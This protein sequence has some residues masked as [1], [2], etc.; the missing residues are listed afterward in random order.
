MA[1]FVPSLPLSLNSA[2]GRPAAVWRNNSRGGVRLRAIGR[3]SWR[4]EWTLD[5]QEASARI[6]NSGAVAL[7]EG[8]MIFQIPVDYCCGGGVMPRIRIFSGTAAFRARLP[9]RDASHRAHI[10]DTHLTHGCIQLFR[11]FS[12]GGFDGASTLALENAAIPPILETA[13]RRRRR[14]Q[15]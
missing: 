1:T 9:G 4:R 10:L 12:S 6:A 13:Y 3:P 7:C 8:R 5:W 2:T 14:E 11:R 15:Q